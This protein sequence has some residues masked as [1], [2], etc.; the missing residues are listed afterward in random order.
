MSKDVDLTQALTEM[1]K[2]DENVV[3]RIFPLV[4]NEMR[5][6]ARA[7]LS[8]ERG[9]HTLQATALVHEA[10][11][12]LV[13]QKKTD[14]QNR[15]HFFAIASQAIRRVLV[16]HARKKARKKRGG[17]A[18]R[19]FLD[20][21]VLAEDTGAHEDLV[22]LDEALEGLCESYPTA[23]RIVELRF[24]GGL[25]HTEVADVLGVSERTARSHWE[26]AR[27]WLFQRLREDA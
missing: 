11:L 6:L 26:F 1:R 13:D 18:E 22:A 9:D 4:Y 16:D 12:R 3:E 15:N 24:Y 10:Y 7:Q 23:G 21:A 19:V 2:G 8:N 17:S 5:Q 20:T 25:T 14:Y 27:T